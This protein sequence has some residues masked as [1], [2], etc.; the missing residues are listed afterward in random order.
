LDIFSITQLT[1]YIL[2]ILANILAWLSQ[3]TLYYSEGVI[4]SAKHR[5]RSVSKCQTVAYFLVNQNQTA[6]PEKL[7]SQANYLSEQVLF[8]EYKTY[9]ALEMSDSRANDN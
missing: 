9:S 4:S 1:G 7:N 2:R 3:Q 8:S 6:R 5:M